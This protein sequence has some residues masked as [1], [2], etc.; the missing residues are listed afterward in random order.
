VSDLRAAAARLSP[1]ESPGRRWAATAVSLVVVVGLT[2]LD[3]AWSEVISATVVVAPFLAAMFAGVRQ[4]AIVAFAATLSALLSG[5][6]NDN[7]GD[8]GYEVRAAIVIVGGIFSVLAA[9]TRGDAMRAE[10]L[11]EQLTAA[12]SNLAEAV[13]VQ[14]RE[15]RLVYANEAAAATLGFPSVDALLGAAP[16]DITKLTDFFNEDGSPLTPEQYPSYRVLRGEEVPPQRLRV[17]NRATGEE[18]WRVNKA[19]GVRDARNEP[20]LVVTV[21]EDITEQQRAEQSQR[22]LARAGAALSS[23]LHYE[24]TLQDVADLAVPTLADWCGV[25][26]P[27]RHG[28]IKQVAVAHS[29]PEKVAFARR[30]SER[31]P[32]RT[33]DESGA[34]QVLRD[35][36]SQLIPDIPDELL[37]AAVQD[38]EQREL[39]REIGM[40]SAISVRSV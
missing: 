25:S 17:I 37:E 32:N 21:I 8:P 12:L 34:A 26:M 24:G 14:D 40:R 15:Q 2:I 28:V 10:A 18:R 9:R 13:V 22:L 27:D 16:A 6:W 35:G 23:S 39:L 33:S 7:F 38:P 3:A 31:Y 30:Y 11:G 19:R 20:R 5:I 36:H 1:H 29:D 4:T